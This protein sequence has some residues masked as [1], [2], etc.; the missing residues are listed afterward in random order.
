MS[1]AQ[2]PAEQRRIE[3]FRA[4]KGTHDVLPPVSNRWMSLVSAFAVHVQRAGYGLVQSPMFEE[5]GVFKRM[6]EG[7]DVVRKEMYDFVDKGDRHIALRPEGTASI[8]RAFIQHRPSIPFKAWY[9]APSF[10]YEAPQAGRFRQHH[11]LGLELIGTSDPDSDVEVITI[12][13]DFYKSLGLREV[14]LV[15]NSMGTP[16]DRRSYVNDLRSFLVDHLEDLA[17]EDREKVEAFPMRVLDSKRPPTMAVIAS[18]PNILDRLSADATSRFER[19][20]DGLRAAGVSYRIE[21]RL[22]RGLD[23]YTHTTFEF[24]SHALDSAQSTVGGGGRYDGLVEALGGPP[25]PGIGFGSGIERLLL[26]C[27]AE[28][29][30]P[31]VSNKP[32]VFVVDVAGGGTA[33]DISIELRRAGISADR[34][35]DKRSMK[36]QMK[37][38]DRSGAV[39]VVIIG[40]DEL[41]SGIVTVRDLRGDRGQQSVARGDLVQHFTKLVSQGGHLGGDAL[42]EIEA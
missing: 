4:P 32:D 13:S 9:A 8:V 40:E 39:A 18:A 3:S 6:G 30:L 11:Q 5:I 17:A 12:L 14:E 24:V 2:N 37:L 7:T 29:V 42:Q 26:T 22:V 27:D 35:F 41:A 38:A 25:T 31:V 1:D 21:P 33:R 16:D 36:S 15:I 10:R 23:Y 28:G 34:A 20:Q 19:V